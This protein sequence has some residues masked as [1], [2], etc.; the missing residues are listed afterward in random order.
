M[1]PIIIPSCESYVARILA[2]IK[3]YSIKIQNAPE[4]KEWDPVFKQRIPGKWMVKNERNSCIRELAD[5]AKLF[6]H[7]VA[8]EFNNFNALTEEVD[9]G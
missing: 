3:S 1:D 5:E 6:G 4:R 9:E 2:V 7:D 8:A